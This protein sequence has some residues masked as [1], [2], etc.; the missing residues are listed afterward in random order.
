MATT[1]DAIVIGTGQ[2]GPPLAERMAGAGMKVAVIE[3]HRFGGTCVNTGCI[4]TKTLVASARAAHVARRAGDFG[5]RVGGR[6]AVDMKK[7]KARKDAI[8]ARS[9]RGVARWMR[10]T[11]NITVYKG[12]ARFVGPKQVQVNGD[13]LEG[14]KIFINVGGRAEVPDMPGLADVPYLTNS[15]M[16]AVDF[17]PRHLVVI[18]GSYIGLEFGQMY[19]R[20]GS[21]VTIVERGDRLIKRE[22]P[23]ISDAVRKI[24]EGE[25]IEVRLNAECLSVARRGRGVSVGLGCR[26]GPRAVA[27]SHLLLAVGRV[28][29][30]GDLGLDQAGVETDKRG[31]IKV[32]DRLATSAP[33]IWALGDCNGRGAFTHTSYNDFEIIAANL[34]DGGSR[35]VTDRIPTY[36]LYI[37]PPL[38]RAGMTEREARATG[39]KLLVGR[40]D[41]ASVGRARERGET[42]GFM[43]LVVDA[44][45]GRVLGAGMLGIEADEVVQSVLGLMYAD[46]PVSLIR[47]AMYVHPTV[48]EYLP[49]LV[50]TLKPAA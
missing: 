30:T 12:H 40:L 24:L 26:R 28:P 33:G 36:A 14:D 31:F 2:S 38:G 9:N 39:R 46:Q 19:R 41:M 18:G 35:R 25:G 10:G 13:M 45:N 8:V 47:R 43:K 6:V 3:R 15:G 17:L 23:E 20:F 32:D 16:M 42:A 27:G 50:E 29:N 21:R 49:S 37:D 34:L 22:D 44:E 7:V 1:Y 11:A 4:P 5:V 48:S